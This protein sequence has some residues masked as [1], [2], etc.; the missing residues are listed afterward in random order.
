MTKAQGYTRYS[1]AS[2]APAIAL[3]AVGNEGSGEGPESYTM[4]GRQRGK[5][6][7]TYR[8]DQA[9]EFLVY[10]DRHIVRGLV[11]EIAPEYDDGAE[12]WS[13]RSC[14]AIA[15]NPR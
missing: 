3:P 5:G 9:A 11:S 8:D 6:G 1:V 14:G 2:S 13:L 7:T 4:G 12:E 10:L 15:E